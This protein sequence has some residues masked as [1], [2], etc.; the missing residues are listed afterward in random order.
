MSDKYLQF[1]EAIKERSVPALILDLDSFQ[2]NLNWVIGNAGNKN[3]RI[4]TK[5]VRSVEILK[6]IHASH[7]V[8]QGYMTYTLEESLW[9][10]SLGL[11]DILMGYPSTDIVSLQKLAKDP[12]EIT[13][14][15]DRIEHLDLLQKIA[16]ENKAVFRICVDIDMSMD[17]PGVR[18][19][20]YRS[21]LQEE[22]NLKAFLSHL[23]KCDQ[24][25][26]TG[27]MG[28]EAQIA[29]VMDDKSGLIRTL[30]K[31][32]KNQLK[33]RRADL[34]KIIQDHGHPLSIVNGGGTGSLQSTVQESVVNEITVGSAF[35]APVL[36]DHYQD[37]KLDPALYFA[38]PIVRQPANNINTVLGGGHIASGSTDDIK[39]PHPILP[40]GL[41]LLKHEGAGEVQTPMKY[42]GNHN[43][44]IGDPVF[45]RHAKAGEICEH[46]LELH[47]I[48]GNKILESVATYRGEGKCFL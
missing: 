17:L 30:K 19:G 42:S 43:L 12:S 16:L 15:V 40:A 13:L 28:Y 26:L 25:K 35:F 37:F 1:K 44:N 27:A 11:K 4:A 46:F 34:V 38:Q 39:Q 32:S 6:R 41:E 18:F 5:S 45:F 22:N 47:L 48:E 21:H 24:L 36:F 10:R 20:V 23:K 3:I 8:F 9:L 29:G 7:P 2:K 31:F 33:K 14:M